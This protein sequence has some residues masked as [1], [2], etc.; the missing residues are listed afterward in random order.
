[1]AQI[2]YYATAPSGVI[3]IPIAGISVETYLPYESDTIIKK[4]WYYNV[5]ITD[6][7]TTVV[8]DEKVSQEKLRNT[9]DFRKAGSYLLTLP[10]LGTENFTKLL[11]LCSA[12]S[13]GKTVSLLFDGK[14][15]KNFW[16][17]EQTVQIFTTIK[18]YCSQLTPSNVIIETVN[19]AKNGT[20]PVLFDKG[21][22]YIT[23]TVKVPKS[24]YYTANKAKIKGISING[25]S[26]TEISLALSGNYYTGN[27]TS[28]VFETSGTYT[29]GA[30]VTT[31]NDVIRTTLQNI[32]VNRYIAPVLS[33]SEFYRN[34]AD[35]TKLLPKNAKKD[36]SYNTTAKISVAP[37][38]NTE[39][40]S[41]TAK[42]TIN[43]T[44]KTD[45]DISSYVT[46]GANELKIEWIN[47]PFEKDGASID[48]LITDY[49]TLEITITD[50]TGTTN[51]LTATLGTQ[52]TTFHL[53]EGGKGAKFGGFA[54]KENTLDCAWKLNV[55]NEIETNAKVI[56]PVLT[57]NGTE[58]TGI[59]GAETDLAKGVHSHGKINADGTFND[60]SAG[61]IV[62]TNDAQDTSK[63][64]LTSR[65][66]SGTD[67]PVGKIENMGHRESIILPTTTGYPLTGYLT[68][69][70][71]GT[72]DTGVCYTNHTHSLL[73]DQNVVEYTGRADWIIS[74][75]I[76][77]NVLATV[78][79]VEDVKKN[80]E[81]AL[82][83]YYID[84]GVDVLSNI[85]GF[86]KNKVKDSTKFT[87]IIDKIFEAVEDSDI[88]AKTLDAM[89]GFWAGII[90]N[91]FKDL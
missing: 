76:E 9:S 42:L 83:D 69:S 44:V 68:V 86:W 65:A 46:F 31:D 30:T 84:K 54:T 28:D 88:F 45:V 20:N 22:S 8:I 74:E 6:G 14:Q 27:F 25:S 10:A 2:Y 72:A 56:T 26:E 32:T 11:K 1:M 47:K 13:D 35:G 71:V 85:L 23:G 81:T 5:L 75:T 4:P 58:V 48:F 79:Y 33:V 77:Q 51:T 17:S 40:T 12:S 15:E 50:N 60:N 16:Q 41:Y 66:I 64:T 53:M 89:A 37:C 55:D 87:G 19:H 36:T 57:L 29:I 21:L 34:D 82:S 7:T 61:F 63:M 39:F 49:A 73:T 62:A 67:L 78:K 91:I 59:G 70:A 18:L 90:D 24:D 52:D 3:K 43:G 80:L 38:V